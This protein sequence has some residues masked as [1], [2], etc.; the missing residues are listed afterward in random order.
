MAKQDPFNRYAVTS[1]Y[2]FTDR[3][4][5]ASIR[6]HGGL[7]SLAVLRAMGIEIPAP[8]GNDWSHDADEM[9]GLDQYVHLCFRP[10]HPME[11]VACQ[12]GRI[13]DR[14]YLQIHPDIL[15]IKGVMFT[16]D[17]SN[18]RASRLSPWKTHWRS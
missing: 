12:D 5:A 1:F 3:K 6:E 8:G 2:H 13:S 11:Y 18:N 7:Y 14:V 9:K 15:Q 16:A 17:V 10:N 4:N